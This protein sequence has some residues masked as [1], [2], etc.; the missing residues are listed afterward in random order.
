MIED[1]GMAA[2]LAA[3]LGEAKAYLRI[4]EDQEDE[5]LGGFIRSAAGIA[6]GFLAEAQIIRS[7]RE[8]I[9]A[10]REWRRLGRT[11]VRAITAVEALAADGTAALLP[12][13]AYA[14]DIDAYGDGWV[15]L[16]QPVEEKRLIVTY[17]AGRASGWAGIDEPIRQG[18]IRLVAHLYSHRDG[19]DDRGPP[20]A[21]AALWRPYRRM[22]IR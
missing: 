5:A 1:P 19:A 11:P 15:R 12:V 3:G 21:I 18:M 22:R 2:A 20:S 9:A 6:E 7:F 13:D 10:G 4:E 17:Q 14:I 16:A 8:T